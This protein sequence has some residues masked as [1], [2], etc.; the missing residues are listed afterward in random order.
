MQ[1]QIGTLLFLDCVSKPSLSTNAFFWSPTG[2]PCHHHFTTWR[3]PSHSLPWP[4]HHHPRQVYWTCPLPSPA[5][6]ARHQV[7]WT[8]LISQTAVG[9]DDTVGLMP[10]V[11][12][13]GKFVDTAYINRLPDCPW[14]PIMTPGSSHQEEPVLGHGRAEL[15]EN[16]G[17]TVILGQFVV[18]EA[19][20]YFGLINFVRVEIFSDALGPYHHVIELQ[21]A[22]IALQKTTLGWVTER[23]DTV[24]FKDGR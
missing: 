3:P 23:E 2:S 8:L 11:H 24:H 15:S 18:G 10:S 19:H 5:T 6:L 22:V 9:D 13:V 21:G 17:G 4:T 20:L 7:T 14:G 12:G 16:H 1:L